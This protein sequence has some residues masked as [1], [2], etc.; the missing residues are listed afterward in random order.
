MLRRRAI[1]WR[2]KIEDL[3]DNQFLIY[4]TGIRFVENNNLNLSIQMSTED[5]YNRDELHEQL[6]GKFNTWKRSN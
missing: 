4:T 3:S 5:I 1:K 6:A 2:L